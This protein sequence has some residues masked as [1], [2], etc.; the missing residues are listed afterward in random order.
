M[1][2]SGKVFL[3]SLLTI[4]LLFP[5]LHLPSA[6]AQADTGIKWKV[7]VTY[8]HKG[9]DSDPYFF[10]EITAIL[11]PDTNMPGS[12]I[13]AGNGTG[14]WQW[15]DPATEQ[16]PAYSGSGA[17]P[18]SMTAI[19]GEVPSEQVRE[20]S[21]GVQAMPGRSLAESED[22]EKRY[23]VTCHSP[24]DYVFDEDRSSAPVP[25]LPQAVLKG[26]GS[27]WYGE[28]IGFQT[29]CCI[30]KMTVT[31]TPPDIEYRIYGTIKD[32]N[33]NSMFESKVVL[34]DF[35]DL[36]TSG[37]L[38]KKLSTSRPNYI[39]STTASDSTGANYE[40]TLQESPGILSSKF[41]VVSV[42]WHDGN[43]EFAVTNGDETDGR[44]VPVYQALCVDSIPEGDC[45][46]WEQTGNGYEA[47][48]EFVY[49]KK[50]SHTDSIM[51]R[52]GWQ[53]GTGS[54]DSMMQGAGFTYYNTYLGVKHI[55]KLGLAGKPFMTKTYHTKDTCAAKPTSAYYWASRGANAPFFG[56]LGSS[57]EKVQSLGGDIYICHGD[58]AA[59]GPDA[60]FNR[61]WHELGHY[62][63][64]NL[65][66]PD[67]GEPQTNHAGYK[68]NSTNDSFIEG[69]AE[70]FSMLTSEH[71]GE[72]RPY[73]YPVGSTWY[74]LEQDYKVWGDWIDEEFATAGILWDLHDTGVETNRGFISSDGYIG[75]VSRVYNQTSDKV[76]LD[77][78]DII[79][80]LQSSRAKT[81]VGM[82]V[83][84]L[85]S[86]SSE[87]LDMIFLNHGAFADIVQRNYIHDAWNETISQTGNTANRMVRFSPVPE[88][89][90]SYITSDDNVLLEVAFR[91][92]EPF[93]EFDYSYTLNLTANQPAYF[94]MP[95]PY[96][97]SKAVFNRLSEDGTVSASNITT[98]D[99]V[100]YWEY[101]DSGP[102]ENA[103]F[104]TIEALGTVPVSSGNTSS[105]P[106]DGGEPAPAQPAGGGCL[107]AT[108]A[109]GSELTPQVQFLR[110]FRDNHILSTASGS[111]FMN[112]FNTWYY[113]FS[114]QVADY[115]R[116]QPWL[117]QT[118]R[119]GIYPLIGILQMA[120]KT[121]AI[122]PG[123]F[124]SLSAGLVASSLIGAVYF[125]PVALLVKQV[126]SGKSRL[127]LYALIMAAV[128]VAV[129]VSVLINS[130]QA[131]MASTASFVIAT[132][133]ISAA[134]VARTAS[135]IL[136]RIRARL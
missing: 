80:M 1:R 60:P 61:E 50:A 72:P 26:N 17:F 36:T 39:D 91:H 37:S 34:A 13:L 108:A 73:Q 103:T 78:A 28:E 55:E 19:V 24:P 5:S 47:E 70:F 38:L 135:N 121:Y 90:G 32:S 66:S 56:G 20:L 87:N 115:E 114:P 15:R 116:E 22:F 49:G 52:E 21:I 59:D 69:F 109:F 4:S 95:P 84:M 107:I 63:L 27:S 122:L 127:V 46:D 77:S 99:S 43:H 86:V 18:A 96:Y 25:L 7:T 113:S 54:L 120:E 14:T 74:N 93:G 89:P 92:A 16:C 82:Y 31:L 58:S 51:E 81:L 102:S 9:T 123:E 134:L 119:V 10:Q 64:Y 131:L 128:A 106:E 12:N 6:S 30:S 67:D 35:R 136:G 126:R 104:K 3:F 41:L 11:V 23:A 29:D 133:A 94:S 112:V 44:Y 129:A 62:L 110:N 57:L 124:G 76:S 68:N 79:K 33:E 42:L 2:M 40:F 117:Q 130:P 48:V 118:V 100:E 83:A 97:P 98:I 111:S 75:A 88:L 71:Y 132:V 65:Y 85:P 45:V 53:K 101:I 8:E 125:S 105:P